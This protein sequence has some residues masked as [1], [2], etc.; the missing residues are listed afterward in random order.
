MK[1]LNPKQRR[2]QNNAKQLVSLKQNLHIG[3]RINEG[4]KLNTHGMC[5]IAYKD[6]HF[7]PS[8]SLSL[9]RHPGGSAKLKASRW[10]T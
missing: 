5:G 1:A 6:P 4:Q 10:P 3:I 9:Y 8:L 7:S 2:T